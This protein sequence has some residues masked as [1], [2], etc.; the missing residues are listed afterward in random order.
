MDREVGLPEGGP[1]VDPGAD[2]VSVRLH[3]HTANAAIAPTAHALCLEFMAAPVSSRGGP[4][5]KP[6]PPRVIAAYDVRF[7]LYRAWSL[8]TAE[9]N[10][11]TYRFASA[12]V[13]VH[14]AV[15]G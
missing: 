9:A 15:S 12:P 2:A 6:G 7:R 5:V 8:K 3:P 11:P 13:G 10:E 14:V 4:G 1:V